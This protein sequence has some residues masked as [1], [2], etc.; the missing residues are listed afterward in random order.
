VSTCSLIRAAALALAFV[1]AV[2]TAARAADPA[3]FARSIAT[4][5]H[6]DARHI[7][8]ADIDRDG[9]LD[10]VAATDDGFMVWVNDGA[11]RFTSQAPRQRPLV[12]A[13]PSGDSWTGAE[14]RDNETIQSGTPSVPLSGEYAH[15]PPRTSSRSAVPVDSGSR[16]DTSRGCRIPR[17]PPAFN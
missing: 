10:V 4:Q 1:P 5:Y 16:R 15:A 11:G 14:S 3:T 9:D 2:S 12:D 7:V 6:V 13:S 17:A 8:T